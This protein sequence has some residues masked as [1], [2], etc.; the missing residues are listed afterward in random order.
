MLLTLYINVYKLYLILPQ[1]LR[2]CVKSLKICCN[3]HRKMYIIHMFHGFWHVGLQMHKKNKTQRKCLA[4]RSIYFWIKLSFYLNPN[5][6]MKFLRN[7][8]SFIGFNILKMPSS[9]CKIL[10]DCKIY[11]RNINNV[12]INLIMPLK[13][14]R[15]GCVEKEPWNQGFK[16]VNMTF[17][18]LNLFWGLILQVTVILGEG[19][20][21]ST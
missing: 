9:K 17:R 10:N 8:E 14:K 6:K 2:F 13:Q 21:T 5:K 4:C 11:Y 7:L 3:I 16:L 1:S 20:F 19:L 15:Y 18:A 12:A